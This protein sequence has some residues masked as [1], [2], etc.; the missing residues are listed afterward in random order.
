MSAN[1]GKTSVSS[2]EWLEMAV[3]KLEI[4]NHIASRSTQ[5]LERFTEL[6]VATIKENNLVLAKPWLIAG[7]LGATI[8]DTCQ[9]NA[10]R[11]IALFASHGTRIFIK[12]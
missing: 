7:T 4:D 5:E 12:A 1:T 2:Q 9:P 6:F 11:G 10:G 8:K 3:L